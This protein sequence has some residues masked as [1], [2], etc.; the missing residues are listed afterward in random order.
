[1]KTFL[2]ATA[3]WLV[4]SPTAASNSQGSGSGYGYD[5]NGYD[6]CS[7]Q[8]SS[9]RGSNC[10]TLTLAVYGDWPYSQ[11]LLDD[12][13]KLLTSVNGDPDV[14]A[15]VHVGDIHSGSMPC[16][17]AG[18]D[19]T[20]VGVVSH[21]DP[22]SLAAV[23]G[24][25]KINPVWNVHVFKV[26]QQFKAP[27]IYTPGDNE[28][29]DCHK[30]K[31]YVSGYPPAELTG[32]RELFFSQP[33][34]SL[35][36]N[37]IRVTSQP[38][39]F[40]QDAPFV[41]NV[42]WQ[43]GRTVLATVNLPG[44]SNDDADPWTPPLNNAAAQDAERIAREAANLRWLQATFDLAT[45][46]GAK[47]IVLLT[48]ADMWDTAKPTALTNYSPFVQKLASLTLAFN[49][50]VLLVNGDSH[51]YKSDQPLV[52]NNRGAVTPNCDSTTSC[53]ISLIHNTAAVPNFYRIVVW[54]SAEATSLGHKYWLKLKIDTGA[55]GSGVFSATNVEYAA[56]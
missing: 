29:A 40:P 24:T 11:V 48:Q 9:F 50:P 37:R 14:K 46:K 49:R 13:G 15:V 8:G 51:V 38:E 23:N 55:V 25:S 39:I 45:A 5:N 30:T 16:T 34:Y 35:G 18:M 53:D 43:Y 56:Y 1:M 10:R 26:F 41:E 17:G 22:V 42:V 27:V 2:F 36:Q 28:W 12:A 7:E 4:L 52:P 21:S 31:Q 19:L 33:G 44:G 20:G 32:V 3:I 47:A 54:G 6:D